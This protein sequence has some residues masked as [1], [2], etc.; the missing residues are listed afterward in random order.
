M[1]TDGIVLTDGQIEVLGR[2]PYSSNFSFLCRISSKDISHSEDSYNSSVIAV[3]KP[4]D[5]ERPLWDYPPG[6]YKR[7]VASYRLSD[8]L[9]WEIVPTTVVRSDGQ[10]GVGSI[11]LFVEADFSLTYFDFVEDI[12]LHDQLVKIAVFDLLINNSDRKAGH[13]LIDKNRHLWAIDNGL[14]FHCEPK[15]RTVIWDFQEVEIPADLL[16]SIKALLDTPDRIVNTFSDLLSP[17]EIDCLFERARRLVGNPYLPVLEE[18]KRPFPWP[19][20]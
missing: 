7:E 1:P 4:Q 6:L 16:K 5:G 10:F 18:S 8:L 14:T 9:N 2:L 12:E 15:L 19:L 20:I 13:I 17:Q 3:Y 11:Q